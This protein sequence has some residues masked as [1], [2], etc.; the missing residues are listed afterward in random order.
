MTRAAYVLLVA[1][2]SIIA[3]RA[4]ALPPD[5]I[6]ATSC[7]RSFRS[8]TCVT[9]WGPAV[10][11]NIRYAPPRDEREQSELAAR[12][13]QWLARCRPVIRAD[14]YGVGR[15]RYAASGCE[16]GDSVGIGLRFRPPSQRLPKHS[17]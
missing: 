13:Q 11:P 3:E 9:R 1:L 14:E 15:Y 6:E 8:F 2:F 7:V 17:D 12:N 10:D 5:E 16:Y 4:L